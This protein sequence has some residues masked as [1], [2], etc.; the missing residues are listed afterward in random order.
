M[1]RGGNGIV[2]GPVDDANCMTAM[3]AVNERGFGNLEEANA[4][5]EFMLSNSLSL[6]LTTL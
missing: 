5:L 3:E 4:R 6:V 1:I 2:D